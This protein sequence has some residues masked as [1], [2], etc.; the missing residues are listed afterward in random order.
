MGESVR[1]PTTPG[2][3]RQHRY[4]DEHAHRDRPHDEAAGHASEADH[5]HAHTGESG[6]HH[7]AAGGH[8]HPSGPLGWLTTIFHVGG[9]S[10]DEPDFGNDPAFGTRAGIRAVWLAL[11]ALALTTFLQAIIVVISGSVALL[12]DTVHNFGDFF[13]SVPLLIAFY[14]VRRAANRRYTYG[15]GRAEDVAGVVIVLSIAFSAGYILWESFAKLLDPQ[16]LRQLPWVAAAAVIG[17][18]GNEAVALFQISTGRR[19][20]SEALIADG[21]HARIDGLTSLAVLIAVAGSALGYPLV[22]P[23]IGLLI[24]VAIIFIA[25]DAARRIWYRLM[26]AVDPAITDS[27]ERAAG[28]VPGVARV[29]G[30]RARWVGHELQAELALALTDDTLE[31]ARHTTDAVREALRADVRHLARATIEVVPIQPAATS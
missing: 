30:V 13:N 27:I 11:A 31:R 15:Y 1:Q 28:G 26:D 10:H 6:H 17:F 8:E 18:I 5:D 23:L 12:A 9:H 7:G 2:D 25:R 29:S 24:G 20:G 3:K 21:L 19:I 22:D 14:L 16:P 4:E